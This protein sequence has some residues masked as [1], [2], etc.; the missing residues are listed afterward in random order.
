[1]IMSIMRAGY[2]AFPISPR[3]SPA[4]VAHLMSKVGVKHAFIG[5]E[6]TMIDLG[7]KAL[8]ILRVQYLTIPEPEL[9]PIPLFE[10][11]FVDSSIDTDDIPYEKRGLDDIVVYLHSSGGPRSYR[12][13]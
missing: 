11:L 10:D 6:Q 3:N 1:M 2:I 12:S 7:N 9:F 13:T 5:R 8:T 4:A